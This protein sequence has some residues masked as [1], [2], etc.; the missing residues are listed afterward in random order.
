L[1]THLVLLLAGLASLPTGD[2]TDAQDVNIVGSW[3]GTST[4]VDKAQ[5]PACKDEQVVYDV[6]QQGSARDT[7]TIR[8]DKVVNGVREFMG[9]FDFHRAPANTWVAEFQNPRVRIRI[10]LRVR[11]GHMAGVLTDE[12]SGRRVRDLALDRVPS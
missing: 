8:A 9:E 11:A 12:P 4:C 2:P 1:R 3:R 6:R 7:V 5:F 10:V